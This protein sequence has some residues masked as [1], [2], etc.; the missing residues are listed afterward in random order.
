[1]CKN[2]KY[3][4]QVSHHHKNFVSIFHVVYIFQYM[5]LPISSNI[6]KRRRFGRKNT[7]Q[8]TFYNIRVYKKIKIESEEEKKIIF[9]TSTNILF[10]I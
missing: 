2:V 7:Q 10:P 3:I 8:P 1:M 4:P 5:M 9:K 6:F